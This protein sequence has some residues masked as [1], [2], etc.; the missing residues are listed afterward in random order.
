M[1]NHLSKAVLVAGLS[2]AVSQAAKAVNNGDLFLGFNDAAGPTSAQ[3]DYV[4]DL[5]AYTDFTTTS[6]FQGT[7]SSGLFTT[8]FGTDGNALNDVGVGAVAGAQSGSNKI[9]FQTGAATGTPS[10]THFSSSWAAANSVE[11]GEA[12]SAGSTSDATWSYEIAVSPTQNDESGTGLASSTVNPES[13]LVSGDATLDLYESTYTGVRG[14]SPT[15]WTLLGTLTIDANSSVSDP[16]A[17]TVD[18]TGS[19]VAVPEPAT[20]GLFAVGGLLA[21]ALRRKLFAKVS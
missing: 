9:L 17:D 18:F 1:K 5:G 12:A 15:A 2:L 4:I 21:H 8:A 19:A 3:N 20:Y 11:G 10:A 16:T 6:T 13:Y 14:A 7:I